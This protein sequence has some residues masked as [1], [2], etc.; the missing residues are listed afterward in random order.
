L[1]ATLTILDVGHG[2]AAI[3]E[4]ELGVVVIDAGPAGGDLLEYL[5]NARIDVI[6]SVVISHADDDHL[7][8]LLA[9]LESDSVEICEV[10]L[11][12]NAVKSTELYEEI[13]FSLAHQ[14]QQQTLRYEISCVEGQA[15]PAVAPEITLEVLGPTK[16]LAGHGPGWTD[17][18]GQT[19]TTN[20][21][22]VVVRVWAGN[23]PIALLPGD[24]DEMGLQYLA[25]R[26]GDFHAKVLVFPHHGGNV[27]E[28][29]NAA[30]NVVF[31][32]ALMARVQPE[33]V[34]FSISRTKYTNPR[35]E[36]VAQVRAANADVRV[37]CTQLSPTC[38]PKIMGNPPPA[39]FGHLTDIHARGRSTDACCAGSMRIELSGE[40]VPAAAAHAVFVAAYAPNAM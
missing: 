33:S 18:N 34:L 22:S 35:Q 3:F 17:P 27:T 14:D 4:G 29:G 10:R 38:R 7:R 32:D 21:C 30:R 15:L 23:T 12:A 39:A 40:A 19:A 2:N 37:A 28:P 20:S 6:D 1:T 24:L 31:T 8:G 9:I 11:N 25:A 26:H 36:I 5:L 13:V 16:H